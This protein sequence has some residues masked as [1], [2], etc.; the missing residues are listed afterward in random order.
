MSNVFRRPNQ[1]ARRILPALSL[2]LTVALCP[3]AYADVFSGDPIDVGTGLPYPIMPGLPLILPGEDLEW[4]TG[5]DS[6]DEGLGGDVDLVVRA[7]GIVSGAIPAPAGA[8][9]GPSLTTVTAGGGSSGQGAESP[10]T[11][12]LSDGS[13]SPPYGNV[14]AELDDRPVS[15]YAFADLDGDGIVG[16]TNSDGSA[17][18][19]LEIEEAEAYVGRQ[20]GLL[21]SG[22]LR[23]SIGIQAAAPASIGGLNVVLVAGVYTGSDHTELYSDGTLLLTRWPFFPPLD[24]KRVF[25]GSAPPP[26]PDRTCEL[27]YETERH[28][29]PVPGAP[30]IG[31]AFALPTDGSSP[32]TDQLT[33][34]SGDAVAARLMVK[35]PAAT[36]RATKRLRL[37][38][39][40]DGL[41]GRELVVAAD[42]MVLPIDGALS[43]RTVRLLPVDRFGNV[44]DPTGA[45]LDVELRTS[46]AARIVSPDANADLA[47]EGVTLTDASG[48]D[49][50]L[51]D[52]AEAGNA[53]IGILVDGRLVQTVSLTLGSTA[54]A[55]ADGVDADGDTSGTV[56]DGTCSPDLGGV[57]CDDNCP[58]TGNSLQSD[59][60]ADGYGNC[61]DGTCIDKPD[62]EGCDSCLTSVGGTALTRTK[63]SVVLGD[64]AKPQ[65]ILLKTQFKAPTAPDPSSETISIDLLQSDSSIYRAVLDS[66]YDDSSTSKLRFTYKDKEG[67]V[68]GITSS[69][70]KEKRDLLFRAKWKA[71]GVG[72]LNMDIQTTT[73]VVQIGEELFTV[74]LDCSGTTRKIRCQ[75][76]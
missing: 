11:V 59:D 23:S 7:A 41:G 31:S 60:D 39:A 43:T 68:D 19:R 6:V 27:E 67:V 62:A 53:K 72:L 20:A 1:F 26:D 73:A 58:I 4:N 54:D 32:S 17:D 71:Q 8:L 18:N 16:P 44:A 45:G 38:P 61:C 46:G 50:V 76:D 74:N 52:T 21:S 15:V 64:V 33:V 14:L 29:R 49:I 22:R 42:R 57:G 5:D 30:V 13:G 47:S 28:L 9:G 3:C 2:M 36:F 12:M 24:P 65:K 48:I 63:L 55:D 34:V 70:I 10:F 40:P 56:G 37:R 66:L 25:E 35:A 75:G 69:Q 51:D